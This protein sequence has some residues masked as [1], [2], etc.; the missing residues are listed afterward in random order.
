VLE[1]L[2]DGAV[3]E[4][5]VRA[6]IEGCPACRET[7][8]RMRRDNDL[9][10]ELLAI[11]VTS[12]SLGTSDLVA[13]E[14]ST[15]TPSPA[16]EEPHGYRIIEEIHRGGQGVVLRALQ[17]AT[18]REVALKT[19]LQGAFATP[20]QQHRFVREAELAAA[21]R[22]P[23]IVTIYDRGITDDGRHYLAMELVDGRPLDV[24][25]RAAKPP[26]PR[27]ELLRLFASLC[28]AV[29]YAHRRG[30]MHRDLKPANIL[31]DGGGVPHILDFGLAK[32]V[33][34]GERAESIATT[35]AG[36][37]VGTFAYAAPEQV[38]GDLQAVDVRSDVYSLGV[39]LYELL[40]GRR[41]LGLRGSLREVV[42]AI[43]EEE[44]IDPRTIDPTIDDDLETIVLTAL[45]KAP[46]RRYQ[47]AQALLDDL[48]RYLRNEPIDAKRDRTLYVLGKM[49]RRHRLAVSVATGLLVLLVGFSVTM[50]VL[51]R[52]VQVAERD[53]ARQ[54]ERVTG[55]MSSLLQLLGS[56]DQENPAAPIPVS[57]IPELL[58]E[59]TKIIDTQL[60]G[61]PEIESQVR[62]ALGLAYLSQSGWDEARRHLERALEARHELYEEPHTAIAESLHNLAR[63]N[64]KRARYDQAEALYRRSL[65]MWRALV[66]DDDL[67]VARTTA[68]LASTLRLQG[69]LDEAEPFYRRALEVRRAL[70]GPD[71][72]ATGNSL[73][74]LGTCLRDL[75][76]LEE[77]AAAFR[78]AI[79]VLESQPEFQP[80]DWRLAR[81][82][83]NLA[84]CLMA[85]GELEEAEAY[86]VR[87][88]EIKRANA[89]EDDPEVA[90]S[91]HALARVKL[92]R[93]G[94]ELV[95]EAAVLCEQA[96]EVQRRHYAEGHPDLADTLHL[97]GE[98]RLAQARPADAA[99]PLREA[100]EIRTRLLGPDHAE[101][102]RAR[103]TLETARGG[104]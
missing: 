97:L 65:A 16:G 15:S 76:R 44:P 4:P 22:H 87:S 61:L 84:G 34:H 43:V 50:S 31:V 66:G 69:R 12:P 57:S 23:N 35:Q 7:L 90:R 80:T 32:D 42:R 85:L 36:E 104:G 55:S 1:R 81:P 3:A 53:R 60:S 71:H 9:F 27:E 13:D 78:G 45:A 73:N 52:I 70:L 49:V 95:E 40:T 5:A 98:I 68:H 63:L 48:S 79:E 19:L 26:L 94:P 54:T 20:R 18:K 58:A 29:A 51:F 99:A 24:A 72:L 62:T 37:F 77:A 8:E 56:I 17:I 82:L 39:M 93:G 64:W 100:V 14:G 59:A 41:P 25:V 46:E 2:A 11:E 28:D 91:L 75:G 88:L 92:V 86:L 21:L 33:I 101:T 103:R 47:S 89:V 38:G 6:H 30:I 74:G 96:L 10:A 67:N 102:Q 83:H